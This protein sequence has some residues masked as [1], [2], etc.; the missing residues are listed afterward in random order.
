MENIPVAET[1]PSRDPID[2]YSEHGHCVL[3][4]T[5]MLLFGDSS[6]GSVCRGA[7]VIL[8]QVVRA[9]HLRTPDATV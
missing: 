8:F 9:A 7:G 6:F 4:A 1:T 2:A 5:T 3:S